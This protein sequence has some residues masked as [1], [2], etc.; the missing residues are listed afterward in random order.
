MT[1]GMDVNVGDD[2]V[3]TTATELPQFGKFVSVE[4]HDAGIERVG[5]DV[6]VEDKLD[7]PPVPLPIVSQEKRSAFAVTL[8][9]APLQL[10]N[11]GRPD[12]RVA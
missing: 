8:E 3:T 12:C 6:V 9:G 10:T 2:A 7:D 4:M 1:A 5:I 11:A